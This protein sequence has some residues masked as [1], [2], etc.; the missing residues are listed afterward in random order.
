[1]HVH[2]FCLSSPFAF[3]QFLP[4]HTFCLSTLSHLCQGRSQTGRMDHVESRCQA[5]MEGQE[6]KSSLQISCALWMHAIVEG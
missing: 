1:M 6:D 2:T 4:V 3:P 5:H